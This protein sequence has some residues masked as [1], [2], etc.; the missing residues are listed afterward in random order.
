MIER[1]A[2]LV[3]CN[4]A[5]PAKRQVQ[6]LVDAKNIRIAR[7]GTEADP[8]FRRVQRMIRNT[9]R[10]NGWTRQKYV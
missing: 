7:G 10:M 6:Q 1:P 4:P 5:R 8:R 2:D 3:R 9:P